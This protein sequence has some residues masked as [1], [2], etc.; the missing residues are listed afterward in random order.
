MN[1]ADTMTE[2]PEMT[3]ERFRDGMRRLAASVTVLTSQGADGTPVGMTATAVCSV[4]SDPPI[5]LICVNRASANCAAFAASGHFAVNVLDQRHAALAGRFATPLP[6]AERFAAGQWRAMATGSP[7][8]ADAVAAFDCRI[9]S[10][11]D[12]GSHTVFFGAV[13]AVS[14]APGQGLPLLYAHGAYG[15]FA[16]HPS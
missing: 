13:L 2:T 16:R 14:L 12:M 15:G 3:P 9:Q 7:I 6:P 8:L 4:S 1:W 10:R 5:L 11:A